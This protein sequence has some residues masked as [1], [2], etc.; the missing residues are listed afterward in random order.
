MDQYK[1]LLYPLMGEKATILREKENKLTFIVNKD[2]TR[3]DV[4]KAVESLYNVK[5][6]KTNIM[7]TTKGKKKAH[8]KLDPKYSAEEIASHFGVL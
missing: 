3:D 6:L 8:V 5:V 7:I 2:A 4:K 1:V